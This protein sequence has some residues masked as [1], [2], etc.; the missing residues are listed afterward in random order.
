MVK[1]AQ[2]LVSN[3]PMFKSWLYHNSMNVGKIVYFFESQC[4][5]L[6]TGINNAFREYLC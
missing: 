2:A 5:H 4:P 1:G 3:S 6:Y